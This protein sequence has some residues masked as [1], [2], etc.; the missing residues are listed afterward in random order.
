GLLATLATKE[1]WGATEREDVAVIERDAR[2]ATAPTPQDRTAN[3]TANASLPAQADG[4]TLDAS[5]RPKSS[6]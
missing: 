6:H 4:S 3:E 1:T 5:S 2:N